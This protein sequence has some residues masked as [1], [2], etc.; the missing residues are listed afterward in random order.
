M[1]IS[2]HWAGLRIEQ[3]RR[4]GCLVPTGLSS[5][6]KTRSRRYRG[7]RVA[8]RRSLQLGAIEEFVYVL[9]SPAA[10]R[11]SCLSPDAK[12]HR[13]WSRDDALAIKL[14]RAAGGVVASFMQ[15]VFRVRRQETVTTDHRDRD[16]R[17]ACQPSTV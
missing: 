2:D 9:P 14:Y 5:R 6:N 12:R 4:P 7:G 3:A 13:D 15:V 1:A 16:R 8:A 17:S 11:E 10:W